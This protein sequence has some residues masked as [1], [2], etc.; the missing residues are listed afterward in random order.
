MSNRRESGKLAREYCKKYKELSNTEVA[1]ILRRKHPDV[2]AE[3]ETA[4]AAVRYVRRRIG[5]KLR[6]EVKDPVPYASDMDEP[7]GKRGQSKFAPKILIYDI[8]TTPMQSWHWGC[9][10]TNINPSQVIKPSRLLCF[11]GKWLGNDTVFFG[12]TQGR[13]TDKYCCEE[14]WRL[15]DEAD[16]IVAHNGQAFDAKTVRARWIHH[17]MQPPSPY[18]QVDTLKLAKSVGKFGIN[19]LDYL[20][21]YMEI[22][23]K[24]EHEGFDLWL[25]CMANDQP[26]WERMEKYNIQDVMLLEELYLRLRPWD[27]KHPNVALMYDDDETRCVICGSTNLSDMAQASYT[28]A[29]LFP[30]VRCEDCGKPMR[31]AT[32]DKQDK[33]TLRHSL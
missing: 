9:Y 32:R 22:G 18:K 2:Y 5:K 21:R 3:V 19:K 33:E 29:S 8:E 12:S 14:L 4:R 17:K 26:A 25:K 15:F 1:R 31:R 23:K 28:N 10:K 6:S 30:S 7:L 27:K 20:G 16:I 11:V 13:R 24:V